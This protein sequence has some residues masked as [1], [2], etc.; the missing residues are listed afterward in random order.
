MQENSVSTVIAIGAAYF[1]AKILFIFLLTQHSQ[2]TCKKCT[3]YLY[4]LCFRENPYDPFC[5]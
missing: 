1:T 2:E 5:V 3:N 4:K